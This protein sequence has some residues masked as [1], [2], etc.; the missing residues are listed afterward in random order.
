MIPLSGTRACFP[1]GPPLGCEHRPHLH[2]LAR[3][4]VGKLSRSTPSR[5]M[6]S[7]RAALA[8]GVFAVE[9]YHSTRCMPRSSKAQSISTRAPRVTRPRPVPA[10]S[11]QQPI[12][13]TPVAASK[14]R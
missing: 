2:V 9:A 5:I 11:S 14:T 6:P 7:R 8:L 10:G 3:A 12:S 1:C 4:P 13:Q